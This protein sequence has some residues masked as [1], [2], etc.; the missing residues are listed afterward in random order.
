MLKI[1][2][3]IAWNNVGGELALFDG[4]DG[5]YHALNES[6]A[7]IWRGIAA[8]L[9][10]TEIVRSL[11]ENHNAEPAEIGRDVREFIDLARTKGLLEGSD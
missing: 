2:P 11:A 4:R 8:G 7:A 10:E 6:S 1:A 9:D 5:T 3:H